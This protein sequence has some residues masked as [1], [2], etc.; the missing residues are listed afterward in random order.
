MPV[1]RRW[2]LHLHIL[3]FV[4]AGAVVC[5]ATGFGLGITLFVVAGIF[6]EVTFW[7]LALFRL[8]KFP[9]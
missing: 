2:W 1:H 7:I 4:L 5:Y 3:L 9:E 8:R 6:L